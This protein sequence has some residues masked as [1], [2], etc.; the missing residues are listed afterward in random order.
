MAAIAGNVPSGALFRAKLSGDNGISLVQFN[1]LRPGDNMQT[2]SRRPRSSET[3]VFLSLR[4]VIVGI[5]DSNMAVK[6][7]ASAASATKREKDPKKRVIITGLGLVSIFGS[8]IDT[9]C[10]KL[11]EGESGI[12]LID[13]FDASKYSIRFASRIHDFSSEGYIDRKN[14]RR[15]D[16]SWRYCLVAGERALEDANLG[17]EVIK[18]SMDRTKIGVLIGTGLGGMKSFSNGSALLGLVGACRALSHRNDE[19]QKASRPRDKDR[20]GFVMGEASGV[21]WDGSVKYKIFLSKLSGDIAEVNAIIDV[22][23]GSPEIKRNWTK[24]LI[25]H[26]RHCLGA[27]SGLE[28]NAIA[29]IKAITTGWL[30]PTIDQDNLE[31][32]VT[33]DTAKREEKHVML[34]SLSL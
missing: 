17:T 6:A 31:P 27:A 32:D 29:T 11:L 34:L 3:S 13:R 14:D 16:D 24:S 21:L 10:N 8:E 20:D 28:A 5:G 15:L 12:H 25:G 26:C 19:P 9:F 1:G 22:F 2:G 18:K 7:M 4:A 33:I 30:H 23:K